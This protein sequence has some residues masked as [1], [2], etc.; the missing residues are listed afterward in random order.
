MKLKKLFSGFAISHALWT[1]FWLFKSRASSALQ[2]YS[3]SEG[4][5][6]F[7]HLWNPEHS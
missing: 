5:E 2:F 4:D 7:T 6:V 3:E 1:M